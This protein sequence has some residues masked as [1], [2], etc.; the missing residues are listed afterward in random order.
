MATKF[1]VSGQHYLF[2]VQ[3][4]A[5]IVLSVGG[6]SYSY[7]LRDNTEAY[8]F[9]MYARN[10]QGDTHIMTLLRSRGCPFFDEAGNVDL[11]TPEGIAALQWLKDSYDEGLF[12]THAENL[13]INDDF[14]LFL[15][16][17]LG[18]YVFNTA[19]AIQMDD[20]DVGFV[21]FPSLSS[22]GYATAFF[23]GFEVFD[24]GDPEKVQVGKDFVK[25]IYHDDRWLSY[26]A[27]DIPVS[28]RITEEYA[29]DLPLIQMYAN[30]DANVVD[31]TNRSPNWRDVRNVFWTHINRMFKG[32]TGVEETAMAIDAD[33]NA[34]IAQGRATSHLHE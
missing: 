27:G 20:Q 8:P 15:D 28:E 18:I 7:A 26:S 16:D 33:L 23:S 14:K 34:A 31:F 32:K 17:K 29:S 19:L 30:N 12:P 4:L 24:N 5:H 6:D 13:E 11:T 21:N 9:F 22:P 25:Y 2:D 1:S 10:E 3:T